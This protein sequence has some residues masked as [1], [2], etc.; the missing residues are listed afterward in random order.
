MA[1]MVKDNY[2][3][4]KWDAHIERFRN[5]LIAERSLSP[6]SVEAYRRDVAKLRDYCIAEQMC[7]E[8]TAV[9]KETILGFLQHLNHKQ[10]VSPRSQ[11]RI[12]S[13][14]KAFFR[15]LLLEDL[16]EHDPTAF[17][18][19]PKVGK[20][21]PDT[22]D[23]QEIERILA[24][25]DLSTQEGM[26]NRAMLEVLYSCGL[27]VSELL[28]LMIEHIYWDI[29]FLKVLG[30]GKKERFVPLGR[31]AKKYL[32]LYLEH[33][34]VQL[35]VCKGH[36]HYVFL[37]RR[38]KRL[39]RVYVFS[40]VKALAQEAGISKNISPHTFRHSFATHLIQGGADLRAVQDMLGH[41]SITTTEIYIH[42]DTDYLR[43]AIYGF[44][45]AYR[46][47]KSEKD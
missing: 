9:Q 21:L 11:A 6:H 24:A 27:R 14:L 35:P 41:E 46:K 2:L 31:S 23:P 42:L 38:G 36:E 44:H 8:P 30:K 33:V 28:G 15:F 22:L 16:L 18:E 4:K 1:S 13:G 25:I 40:V 34:R 5:Y 37:N 10:G 12:L 29:D 20:K 19:A 7:V 47:I 39:S 32:K 17:L 3:Q 45:P 26:R 43:R